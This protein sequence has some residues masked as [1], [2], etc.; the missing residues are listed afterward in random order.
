MVLNESLNSIRKVLK[1]SYSK[2]HPKLVGTQI[3]IT[4]EPG[5]KCEQMLDTKHEISGLLYLLR[6]K[7]KKPFVRCWKL[8]KGKNSLIRK[9]E[10]ALA[11]K[12]ADEIYKYACI[13]E[14]LID[15]GNEEAEPSMAVKWFEDSAELGCSDAMYRVGMIYE[16]G[17][18]G[19]EPNAEISFLWYLRAA[20]AG[21]TEAYFYAGI[22]CQ[23]GVGIEPDFERAMKYYRFG[24]NEGD[25]FCIHQIGV[26]YGRGLGVPKN[27]Q[28][29]YEYYL[30][31]S[32]KSV[33]EA[34]Q[35]IAV[36]CDTGELGEVDI[37]KAMYYYERAAE[38]GQKESERR[39]HELRAENSGGEL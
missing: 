2:K 11:G 1:K 12:D 19:L 14:N 21:N 26:M 10:R 16:I 18:F 5:E 33:P 38:L 22:C 23:E 25:P 30:K 4:V 6:D 34:Y 13:L 24:E 31:A 28:M 37:Q 9:Y 29:A 15:E 7:L 36:L 27:T 17:E 32:V 8:N 35:N 20:D 3:K 39:L